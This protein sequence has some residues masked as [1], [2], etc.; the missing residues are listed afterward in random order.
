MARMLPARISSEVNSTAERRV[1]EWLQNDPDAE[2]W[3]VLHSLGLARHQTLLF[4][5]IDFVVL[6]PGKGIFCLEVKGGRVA[7]EDGFWTFTNRFGEV[8]RKSRGPFDQARE[9][10]FSLIK[11]LNRRLPATFGVSHLLFGYGVIF[12]DIDFDVA[13]LDYD[14]SQ[15]WDRSSI[16]RQNISAFIR[17]LSTYTQNNQVRIYGDSKCRK[18]P[19]RHQVKQISNVLRGDFDRPVLLSA[20]IEEADRKFASLTGE[21]LRCLDMFE[22]NKRTL[23]EGSAGTG[24]TLLAVEM[25]RRAMDSGERVALFCYNVGLANWIKG[26]FGDLLPEGSFAGTFHSFMLSR[27][28]AKPGSFNSSFFTE[29]LPAM[30]LD[31]DDLEPAC[32]DRIIIDEAQDL[33]RENYLLVLDSFLCGGFDRGRWALFGDFGKQAIYQYRKSRDEMISLIESFTTFARARLSKNCRNTRCI[34]YAVH[35]LSGVESD[36]P[37]G[38]VLG[39]PVEYR[40]WRTEDEELDYLLECLNRLER[41]G[42]R[43]KDIVILTPRTPSDSIAFRASDSISTD[44]KSNQIRLSSIAGFKGLESRVVILVDCDSYSNSALYYVGMTRARSLLIIMES[45]KAY[46]QRGELLK[47]NIHVR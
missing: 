15:V 7:R 12:T 21:Q 26:Q 34:G 35:A 22:D 8:N 19:T 45:T 47:E 27:S 20:Q 3:V 25:A 6:A 42:V 10:M 29:E 23:F 43:N 38:A 39:K 5:E 32:F 24:K 11:E 2:G 4:G 9:C 17:R 31:S 28:G 40:Q 16:A 1:F 36:Y 37:E 33:V 18:Y 13:D 41:E 46:K 44:L 14:P 30:V